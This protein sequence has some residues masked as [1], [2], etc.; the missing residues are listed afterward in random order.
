MAFN[1]HSADPETQA[2][3]SPE[4]PN[5]H[6]SVV[7]AAACSDSPQSRDAL[8]KLCSAY[9]YPLYAYTRRR[10]HNP[11]EAEDLTQEFFAR[12]LDKRYLAGITV[13]GSRFRSYLL[14]MVKHFLAKEWHKVQAQKRGGSKT[15]LSLDVDAAEDRYRFE[16]ADSETPETLFERR[17]ASTLLD[18]VMAAL[19]REYTRSEEH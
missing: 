18:E 15:I 8:A 14:T 2:G 17:W 7:L 3:G 12:L 11:Q 4:F 9:W 19:Q 5:T 13:E 10:G 16:P 1:P 6:W